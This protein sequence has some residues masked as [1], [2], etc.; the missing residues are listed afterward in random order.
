M[1]SIKTTDP[2]FEA[3]LPERVKLAILPVKAVEEEAIERPLPE[4]SALAVIASAVSVSIA[5]AV[6]FTPLALFERW[7]ISRPRTAA[8]VFAWSNCAKNALSVPAEVGF[9]KIRESSAEVREMVTSP[10]TV[11]PS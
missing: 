4:V 9:K 1:L 3:L 5:F 11:S 8:V 2:V 6:R 10:P 7:I